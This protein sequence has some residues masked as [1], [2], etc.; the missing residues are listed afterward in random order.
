MNNY[1]GDQSDTQS[2]ASRGS[3]FSDNNKLSRGVIEGNSN[4][5]SSRHNNKNTGG[6]SSNTHAQQQLSQEMKSQNGGKAT[7]SEAR[8]KQMQRQ[9][10]RRT[11]MAAGSGGQRP[12]LGTVRGGNKAEKNGRESGKPVEE[13]AAAVK[14]AAS[15]AQT[16]VGSISSLLFGRKGGLL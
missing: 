3:D 14:P 13:E 5:N 7:L 11:M 15:A 1:D 2:E 10:S 4:S 12:D 16:F 9:K 8:V 6:A